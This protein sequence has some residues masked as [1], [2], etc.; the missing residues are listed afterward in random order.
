MTL[1]QPRMTL[2]QPRM[3]LKQPRMTLKLWNA[4]PRALPIRADAGREPGDDTRKLWC[5]TAARLSV[6]KPTC[7]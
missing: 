3:T 7:S 1:K 5:L 6:G 2:K 4:D